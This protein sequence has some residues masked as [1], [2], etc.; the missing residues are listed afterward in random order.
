[1]NDILFNADAR[2]KALVEGIEPAGFRLD[3]EELEKTIANQ[4]AL[5]S[6]PHTLSDVFAKRNL[7]LI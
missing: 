2:T 1:M 3:I 7:N 6:E 5:E 4:E